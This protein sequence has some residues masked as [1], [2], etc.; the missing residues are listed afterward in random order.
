MDNK[1]FREEIEA[2]L[3][4]I[5]QMDLRMAQIDNEISRL[6]ARKREIGAK[7]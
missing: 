1:K 5:E 3:Q 4:G 2:E 7:K 6:R